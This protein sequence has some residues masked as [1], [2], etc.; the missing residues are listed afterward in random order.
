MRLTDEL[1][2]SRGI[3]G[4]D[5]MYVMSLMEVAVRERQQMKSECYRE[6][7]QR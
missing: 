5:Q 7:E 6:A 4:H 1:I 2:D 3:R